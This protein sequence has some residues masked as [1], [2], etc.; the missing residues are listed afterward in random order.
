MDLCQ[1]MDALTTELVDAP[2]QIPM[3]HHLPHDFKWND[4]PPTPLHMAPSSVES[5]PPR[6]TQPEEAFLKTMRH[7]EEIGQLLTREGGRLG[8]SN[9]SQIGQALEQDGLRIG[10]QMLQS[11]GFDSDR[12]AVYGREREREEAR[13]QLQRR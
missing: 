7:Y 12:L 11:S 13:L 5:L 9:G 4:I 10:H 6:L 3:T 8:L 1:E 2:S